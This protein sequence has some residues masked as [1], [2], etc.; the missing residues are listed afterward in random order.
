MT[1]DF[2][3]G[4]LGA[5]FMVGA[6]VSL[7]AAIIRGGTIRNASLTGRQW[8]IFI[9]LMAAGCVPLLIALIN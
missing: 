9:A 3:L 6:G 2:W 7:W 4:L 1:P 8:T 5:A